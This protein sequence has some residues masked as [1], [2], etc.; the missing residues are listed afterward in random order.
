MYLHPDYTNPA[1]DSPPQ[2]VWDEIQQ[3]VASVVHGLGFGVLPGWNGGPSIGAGTAQ[4]PDS[5]KFEN[6]E[7]TG[8]TKEKMRILFTYGVGGSS[9]GVVTEMIFEHTSDNEGTW[10]V[11]T[12]ITLSYSESGAVPSVSQVKGL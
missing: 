1:L 7:T 9:D 8:S 6:N 2:A 3:N 12:T 11:I 5:F 10:N 4:Q